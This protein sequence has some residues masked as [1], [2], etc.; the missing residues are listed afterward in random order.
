MSMT[1]IKA[2]TLEENGRPAVVKRSVQIA[3][4]DADEILAQAQTEAERIVSEA[5]QTAQNIFDS[6]REEGYQN[7]AAQWNDALAQAWKARDNY[8]ASNE[9]ALLKLAVRIAEKLIGQ[10]LQARPDAIAALVDEA[11]RSVRRAK[12]F[13]IQAHPADVPHLKERLHALRTPSGADREI[14]V[15]PNASLSRGDC[16]V[17]TDI[18]TID[19]RLETQLKNIERALILKAAT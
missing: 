13:R 15:A 9:T 10:E 14:E 8:L 1:V 4:Q 6:G 5:R 2:R 11:L 12:T 16:I 17:E 19:A 18:G 3:Y 7:G